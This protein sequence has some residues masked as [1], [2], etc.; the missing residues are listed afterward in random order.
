MSTPIMKQMNQNN[1]E[2][3]EPKDSFNKLKQKLKEI[4]QCAIG[5]QTQPK[6][7]ETC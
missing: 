2:A 4:D 6:Y 5:Q 7:G 1:T 3:N